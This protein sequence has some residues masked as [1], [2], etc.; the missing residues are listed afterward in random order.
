M[1]DENG[2]AFDALTAEEIEAGV[3]R[4]PDT[5]ETLPNDLRSSWKMLER[6]HAYRGIIRG[7]VDYIEA[8]DSEDV[9]LD[10]CHSML[11]ALREAL[12]AMDRWGWDTISGTDLRDVVA[13]GRSGGRP[14]VQLRPM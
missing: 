4:D 14:S 13:R 11:L 2:T 3:F 7:L 1:I 8:Y 9:S 12:R 5:R 10:G 6:I